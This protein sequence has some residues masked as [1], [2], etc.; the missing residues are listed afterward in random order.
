MPNT[1]I[2]IK[3]CVVFTTKLLTV[4]NSQWIFQFMQLKIRILK[5]IQASMGFEPVTS[6]LPV[7]CSTNWAIKP[8]IGSKVNCGFPFS[9]ERSEMMLSRWND[10]YM[11]CGCRW[12]CEVIIAVNFLIDAVSYCIN[13]K[14]HYDD[15]FSLSSTCAVHTWIIS[16]TLHQSLIRLTSTLTWKHAQPTKHLSKMLKNLFP[17]FPDLLVPF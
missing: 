15:H 14:F 5:K 17:V 3:I 4:L 11:N 10:P 13:W 16:C 7:R 8:H 6:A 2:L 9:R 1:K 12:K